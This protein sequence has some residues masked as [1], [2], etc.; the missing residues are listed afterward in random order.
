MD[1]VL[2]Y[3]KLLGW[4]YEYMGG[5]VMK[6][7]LIFIFC[8]VVIGVFVDYELDNCDLVNG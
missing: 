5:C 4:W 2:L 7:F 3:V 1:V 6:N 8:F